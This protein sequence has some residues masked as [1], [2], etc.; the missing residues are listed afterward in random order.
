MNE[1]QIRALLA[2]VLFGLWPLLMN[3]SGLSGSVSAAVFS[4]TAV[5]VILP[6]ALHGL[7]TS[8]LAQA[9]WTYALLGGLVGAIGVL[10]FNGGLAKATPQTVGTFFV[11]MM[12]AQI[13][14]PAINEII[15]NGVSTTKMIGLML[16]AAA[17]YFLSK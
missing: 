1:L 16:A 15:Q 8:K 2:G 4:G 12:M 6:F 5:I 13:A 17:T 9:N 14:V 10:F 7:D 11:L 3:R